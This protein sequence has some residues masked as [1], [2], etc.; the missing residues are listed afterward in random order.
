MPQR[1]AIRNIGIT[2]LVRYRLPVPGVLSILHRVSGVL[3]FVLLPWLLWLFDMSLRSEVGYQ[4]LLQV[5]GG[6]SI[7]AILV[8]LAWAV[9]HHLVAGVR[10]LALDLDLGMT[11]PAARRS[12]WVVFAISLPLAA[13]AALIIF[14]VL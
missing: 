6:W 7:R 14:G 12:A 13:W 8:V 1:R 9:L 3:M 10:F 2:D 4:R 5:A 11:R